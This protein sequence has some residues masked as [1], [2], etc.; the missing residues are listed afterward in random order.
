MQTPLYNNHN[1]PDRFPDGAHLG[2]WYTRFFNRY[3]ENWEIKK[4]SKNEDDPKF[5]WIK[6]FA[7]KECGQSQPLQQNAL[8]LIKLNQTLDGNFAICETNWH[9]ATGLGLPH[10]VENGLTWHPTLGVPFL[11]GSAIK[12][13]LRAWVE[14]WDDTDRDQR[15]KNWFGEQDEA[16]KLIF[17]DAIPIKPVTLTAD[18]LTPHY[19][20]WYEKGHKIEGNDLEEIVSKHHDKLPADWHEPVPVPFLAVKSAKFLISI[21]A[22]NSKDKNMAA[23]AFESLLQALEFTGAGSKTAVGYGHMIRNKSAEEMLLKE[24]NKQPE[25]KKPEPKENYTDL[26]K[27][28][29]TAENPKQ[30]AEHIKELMKKEKKWKETSKAKRPDRDKDYQ[31]TLLVINYLK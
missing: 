6:N 17:F 1:A 3:S 27:Q 22:R 11:A 2:L 18:I 10:P 24:L 5:K 23:T 13:L 28:L 8:N 15:L 29:D 20:L 21:A 25:S 16:G 4:T 14:I 9:F 19:G 7:G 26:I 30:L 12:G 31:R